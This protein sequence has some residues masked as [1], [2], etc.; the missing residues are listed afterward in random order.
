MPI[1]SHSPRCAW[2]VWI[3]TNKNPILAVDRVSCKSS[4]KRSNGN[5]FTN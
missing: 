2:L 1:T 4:S 5:H 3:Q